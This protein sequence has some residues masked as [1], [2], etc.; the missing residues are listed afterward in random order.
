M[1]GRQLIC[2]GGARIRTRV[3]CF[4]ESHSR[5]GPRAVDIRGG[6]SISVAYPQWDLGKD[7]DVVEWWER[8]L[9]AR[10]M[11]WYQGPVHIDS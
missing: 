2:R 5:E 1:L 10:G 11:V 7:H 4:G 9:F 8:E 3:G 6:G